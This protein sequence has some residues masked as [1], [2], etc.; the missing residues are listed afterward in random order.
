MPAQNLALFFPPPPPAF[1]FVVF[2]ES[3]QIRHNFQGSVGFGFRF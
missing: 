2:P 3:T 1:P